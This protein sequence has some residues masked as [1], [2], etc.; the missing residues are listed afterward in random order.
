MQGVSHFLGMYCY[1]ERISSIFPKIGPKTTPYLKKMGSNKVDKENK[2]LPCA[3]SSSASLQKMN[4]PR[5]MLRVASC[6]H[7]SPY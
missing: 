5:Q 1:L 4:C 6:N 3:R 7:T 2:D